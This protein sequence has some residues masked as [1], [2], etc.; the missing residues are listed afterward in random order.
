MT[1]TFEQTSLEGLVVIQREKFEDSRGS[2]SRL[3]CADELS[4][5]GLQES[6]VQIN[7][8]RTR[9]KGAVRGLHYQYPPQSEIKIV[10]CIRGEVFDVA[11]DLRRGSETFL[12]WHGEV[13][14]EGNAR[15]LLIPRGFAHGFQALGNDCE[16]IYLHSSYYEPTLEGALHVNDPRLAISW[17][18]SVSGLSER[19]A[20]HPFVSDDF[21]G[22]EL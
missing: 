19:D 8:S 4:S 11:V 17:P 14:S 22:V 3:F 12:Q 18:L 2:F 16:L 20:S 9:D 1:F 15:S 6:I 21:D 13:L 10:S 7:H 5:L